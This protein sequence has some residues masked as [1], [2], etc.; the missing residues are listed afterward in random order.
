V[1][2]SYNNKS[3]DEAVMARFN[4]LVATATAGPAKAATLAFGRDDDAAFKTW[5]TGVPLDTAILTLDL[6]ARSANGAAD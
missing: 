5:L 3:R 4:A 6:I 2:A 1:V